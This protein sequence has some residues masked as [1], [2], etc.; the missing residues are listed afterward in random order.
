MVAASI[1]ASAYTTLD[2]GLSRN[3]GYR[4]YGMTQTYA[5]LR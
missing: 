1:N 4:D 3:D 2:S 5:G